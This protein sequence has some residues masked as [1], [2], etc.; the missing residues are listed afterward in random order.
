MR[1]R[2]SP[3]PVSLAGSYYALQWPASVLMDSA[4]NAILGH[5]LPGSIGTKL[6][7]SVRGNTIVVPIFVL[8]T[9]LRHRHSSTCTLKLQGF[10]CAFSGCV[11]VL[12]PVLRRET[13]EVA[14]QLPVQ[15]EERRDGGGAV[16]SGGGRSGS[17]SGG[18]PMMLA[19]VV[20]G[21]GKV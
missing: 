11:Q 2:V 9:P 17:G 3:A 5:P 20:A 16:T 15:R 8:H 12:L 19:T 7:D 13:C 4:G 6:A 18:A 10:F 1:S 14:R 21:P